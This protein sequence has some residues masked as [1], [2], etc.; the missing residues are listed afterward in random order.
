L[1]PT[2][3]G[4]WDFFLHQWRRISFSLGSPYGWSF[5]L[6]LKENS[7]S[8]PVADGP[9]VE[10]WRVLRFLLL[11][12]FVEFERRLGIIFARCDVVFSVSMRP[13]LFPSALAGPTSLIVGLGRRL[14]TPFP[15]FLLR[16]R[17]FCRFFL[18]PTFFRSFC[19]F[20][21]ASRSFVFS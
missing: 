12:A 6:P 18:S 4:L 15:L 2:V 16:Y 21:F 17:E 9:S 14:V 3:E 7:P 13:T 5:P 11:F 10:K 20:R 19:S 1:P 8:W